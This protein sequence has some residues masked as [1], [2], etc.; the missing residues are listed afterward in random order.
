MANWL[1][2]KRIPL[3]LL[4]LTCENQSMVAYE[5]QTVD[6]IL[7]NLVTSIPSLQLIAAYVILSAYTELASTKD[8][9]VILPQTFSTGKLKYRQILKWWEV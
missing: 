3:R 4:H 7:L 2:N 5:I 1:I 9:A 8:L 6:D